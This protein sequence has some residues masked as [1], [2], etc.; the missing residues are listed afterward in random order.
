[1]I[2]RPPRSTRTDTLFPYTTLFRSA[3]DRSNSLSEREYRLVDHRA[4]DPVDDES[5]S[6]LGIER[7]LYDALHELGG[8]RRR[9]VGGSES[10]NNLD[11]RHH[12]NGVEEVQP[13]ETIRT[14]GL[15]PEARYRNGRGGVRDA[16]VGGKVRPQISEDAVLDLFILEIGRASCRERECE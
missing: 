5:G 8:Q 14:V 13:D 10:A 1:M 11:K 16:G 15:C 4:E 12:R 7:R 6:I 2:R 3:L 9:L